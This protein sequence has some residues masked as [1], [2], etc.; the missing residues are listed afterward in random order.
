MV[1]GFNKL[2]ERLEEKRKKEKYELEFI[3]YICK[4]MADENNKKKLIEKARIKNEEKEYGYSLKEIKKLVKEQINVAKNLDEWEEE[5]KKK[6]DKKDKNTIYTSFYKGNDYLAEQIYDP[7]KKKTYYLLYYPEDEKTEMYNEIIENDPETNEKK[8]YHVIEDEEVFNEQIRLPSN[9]EEYG[10]D[11]ELDKELNDF[12]NEWLDIPEDEKRFAIYNI[13]KSWVYDKFHTLNY[14]RALGDTGTGK[15]RFLDVLGLLHYKPIATSGA[16]TSAVLFRV[17]DKWRGS[18]IMD[19]A[20]IRKDDEKNDIIKIINQGYEKGRYVMR[21]DTNDKEKIN[22]FEVYCPKI[23]ATRKAFTDKATEGRCMTTVMQTTDNK[24]IPPNLNK[25]FYDQLLHLRNKLLLWRFRNYYKIDPNAGENIDLGNIDPRMRQITTGFVSMFKDN[26]IEIKRF[27]EYLNNYY[28]NLIEERSETFEGV[29]VKSIYDLTNE[30]KK[31]YINASMIIE[32]GE[33][34]DQKGEL[35]KPRRLNS[36]MK[37]LGFE[38]PTPKKV[39]GKTI[40]IYNINKEHLDSLVKKY[41]PKGYQVT[42]VTEVTE[43]GEKKEK[44]EKQEELA[45]GYHFDSPISNGNLGN[46]V[47][48]NDVQD[49]ILTILDEHSKIHGKKDRECR[50][51]MLCYIAA[52]DEVKQED[53]YNEFSKKLIES[54]IECGDIF[55]PRA[56]IFR[57]N[58]GISI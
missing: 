46:S 41:I 11:K 57:I 20:D 50:K 49:S 21:C 7:E 51:C 14:L 56:G 18:L 35:W 23:I 48:S 55:S 9:I 13:R 29:I 24:D 8:T 40:K 33:L 53:L 3:S 19:E 22:F 28:E 44:Q 6:K 39:D 37:M 17:I 43:R 4:C 12:I 32:K 15:S 38:K 36:Y 16:L 52:F 34:R 42:E 25:R 31:E 26:P 5:K 1:D 30:D 27:K 54:S 47:T 2:E 10:S 45:K 58:G